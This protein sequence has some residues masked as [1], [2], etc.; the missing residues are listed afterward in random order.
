MEI[1]EI[2]TEKKIKD[3][4]INEVD[5]PFSYTHQEKRESA[6]INKTRNEREITTDT[7]KSEDYKRVNT[8]N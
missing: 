5:K 3:H 1:N 8:K 6:Q 4:Q 7:K 2:E